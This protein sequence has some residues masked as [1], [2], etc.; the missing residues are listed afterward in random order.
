MQPPTE[1]ARAANDAYAPR[2]IERRW[3]GAWER[4]GVFATPE[5]ADGERGTY[6]MPVPPFTSGS[7]HMGHIRNYTLVDAYAR[8]RRARGDAVLFALG[9]DSFGLPSELGAIE[10]RVHP[11]SW[12]RDC[13]RRMRG[14]FAALGYSFDWERTF[15][16]CEPDIYR[17]S[18]WLFIKLLEH[19][20]VYRDEARVDWCDSCGTVLARLQVENGCCSRCDGPVRLIAHTQW[21]VRT[22]AYLDEIHDTLGELAGWDRMALGAVRAT[23]GR[24]EGVE[25]QAT[26][27]D[28]LAL[29][30]FT[31]HADAIAEG[32]FVSLSPRHPELDRWI[33]DERVAERLRGLRSGGWQRAE[34]DAQ[35]VPAVALGRHVSIAGVPRAL[36]VVVSPSVDARFGASAVL[37]IPAREAVDRAIVARLPGGGAPPREPAGETP[38]REPAG[39]E[40]QPRPAVRYAAGDFPISRQRAWGAPIPLIHCPGCGTLPVPAKDLPVRLPED[41]RI[42]G[43]G[44]PLAEHPTFTACECPHCGAGARRET[45]TLDC[46]FDGLWL[47]VPQCVPREDRSRELFTHPELRSWLPANMVVWGADGGSYLANERT[48]AK[49]LRDAGTF[50]HMPADEPYAHVVMHE[51]VR[52]DGRK[53]SKHL[54]NVVDPDELLELVGADTVRFAVLDA[55][56]PRNPINWDGEALDHAHRVLARLW[57]YAHPR[58]RASGL[59]RESAIDTSDRLRK[60][61]A[62]RCDAATRRLTGD[63]N[64]LQLHRATR[65]A[66]TLL[67]RIEEFERQA[68]AERGALDALDREALGVALAHLVQ[69]AAPLLPHL[70]EELWAAAGREPFVCCEPWP[71]GVRVRRGTAAGTRPALVPSMSSERGDAHEKLPSHASVA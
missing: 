61:L 30:V 54:G 48:L 8:F 43:T 64:A 56:A 41:L 19:D 53:M 4:A 57:S 6:I 34:R 70:A 49:M 68:L 67:S 26:S 71:E 27:G 45:D 23:L 9:F 36:P 55:A 33:V 2:E 31:P 50:A 29:S 59:T 25:L 22:S 58:L 51:M 39:G 5:V 11:G 35:A 7:A 12:V 69:T 65:N 21:F 18:Q 10:H 37:G 44:N 46:N 14:Q 13:A 32:A 60:Q 3:Q 1:Q 16:S 17:W 24:V 52:F 15:V 63:Y 28:G 62:K 40:A 42:T 20:L 47:W 38:P 66:V